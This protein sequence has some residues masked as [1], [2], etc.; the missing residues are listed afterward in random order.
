MKDKRKVF[1]Y[2][3]NSLANVLSKMEKTLGR[4]TVFEIIQNY[5]KEVAPSDLEDIT[6]VI[7]KD[8]K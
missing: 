3:M 5:A 4:E 1:E 8:K 2:H 6:V 7:T